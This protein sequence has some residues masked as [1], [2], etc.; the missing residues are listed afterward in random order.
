MPTLHETEMLVRRF[1]AL[2]VSNDF[3]A[4]AEVLHPDFELYWPQSGERI[5]GAFNFGEMNA[6]YPAEGR[7]R[8]SLERLVADDNGAV[9]D[10]MVTDGSMEARA[11]TFFTV[12]DGKIHRIVEYWP[13]AFE[14]RADRARW[15]ET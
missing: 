7:W 14:P 3:H 10:V 9:T 12:R 2:M 8:F 4:V 13:E 5:C 1:W 6:N 15:V 11:V